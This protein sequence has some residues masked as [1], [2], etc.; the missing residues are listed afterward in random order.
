MIIIMVADLSHRCCTFPSSE[1]ET[2]N[3]LEKLK[4]LG[5]SLAV[6]LAINY[7]MRTKTYQS[8]LI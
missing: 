3:L 7:Y 8:R 5:N 2:L 6:L 1:G 4:L